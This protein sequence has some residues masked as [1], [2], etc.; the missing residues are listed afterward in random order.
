M[1]IFSKDGSVGFF[2]S[3][4]TLRVK[5]Q[6]NVSPQRGFAKV[7]QPVP[8]DQVKIPEQLLCGAVGPN[9]RDLPKALAA[10]GY[11]RVL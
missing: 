2:A 7:D 1:F 5:F 6:V 10:L 4:T 8:Q 11:H 3:R 9:G